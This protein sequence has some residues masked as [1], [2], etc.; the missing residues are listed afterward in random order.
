MRF[1]FQIAPT[2]DEK[3][4]RVGNARFNIKAAVAAVDWKEFLPHAWQG[5]TSLFGFSAF[6]GQR[7][8]KKAR[9]VVALSRVPRGERGTP[10]S[11]PAAD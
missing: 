8:T 10:V 1:W 6:G 4:R 11:P 5:W 9:S 2:D 3:P 7:E